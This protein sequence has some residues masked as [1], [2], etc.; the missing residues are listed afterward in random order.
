MD[1]NIIRSIIF[2]IAGLVSIIFSKQLNNFKNK[3]LLKLNQEN[4]IKDETKQYYYLG[5]LF[6][7][8]AIILFIYSLNN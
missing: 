6:I 5:I 3:I 4:K 8:I 7:I 1:Y 2:L